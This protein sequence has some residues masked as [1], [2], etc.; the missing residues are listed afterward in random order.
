MCENFVVFLVLKLICVSWVELVG[1]KEKKQKKLLCCYVRLSTPSN[2]FN[3]LHFF[4]I[5][6]NFSFLKFFFSKKFQRIDWK[7]FDISLGGVG[8]MWRECILTRLSWNKPTPHTI[9][10]VVVFCCWNGWQQSRVFKIS[11]I[12]SS[13]FFSIEM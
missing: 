10:F 2:S 4:S 5:E 3:Y 12:F 9:P 13:F 6:K 11:S 7:F 8:M 1:L